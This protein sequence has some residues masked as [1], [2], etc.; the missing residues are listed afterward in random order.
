MASSK[1]TTGLSISWAEFKFPPI[2][3]W[4]MASLSDN[5]PSKGETT[6]RHRWHRPGFMQSMQPNAMQ[7]NMARHQQLLAERGGKHGN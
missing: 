4:V 5:K 6:H 7:I 2:N 3:L 1:L